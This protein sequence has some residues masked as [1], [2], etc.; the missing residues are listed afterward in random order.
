MALIQIRFYYIDRQDRIQELVL[1]IVRNVWSRGEFPSTRADLAV[2]AT[3]GLFAVAGPGVIPASTPARLF[4]VRRDFP[5]E[6]T[7]ATFA[8]A[9]NWTVHLLGPR[10]S[11]N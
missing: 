11:P 8:L 7:T 5:G 6:I 9:S 2:A 3:S 4:F 1:D 10:T